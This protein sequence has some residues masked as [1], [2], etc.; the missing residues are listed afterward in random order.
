MA[1]MYVRGWRDREEP[2]E[3]RLLRGRSLVDMSFD[4]TPEEVAVWSTRQSAEG[5]CAIFES[6][7]VVI[8]AAGGGTHICKDFQI[9]ERAPGEFVAF[10]DAPFVLTN[11]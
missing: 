2:E 3:E 11:K 5:D 1:K 9:E 6:W 10:C 8:P 7:Q 4:H